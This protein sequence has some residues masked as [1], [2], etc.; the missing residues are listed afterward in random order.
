MKVITGIILVSLIIVSASRT[1]DVFKH[2]KIHGITIDNINDIDETAESLKKLYKP[3][4]ARIVFDGDKPASYYIEAVTKLN[5]AGFV[6]GELL[7]SY[8]FSNYTIGE[9]DLRV[10]EYLAAFDKKI[11]IWEIAN[12][13][14]GEWLGD[15]DTVVKKMIN[16]FRIVNSK[17]KI[18]AVTFYYNSYC[19]QNEKNEMFKWI[20]ENVPQFMKD[21]LN[22][23]FVSYYEDDCSGFQPDWQNIFDSLHLIFPNSK[24]GIGEC[25]TNFPEKKETYLRRY[26][27]MEINT[28]NYIGGYFWWYYKQDCVPYTKQ[29]WKV[30][31]SI[32]EKE[33]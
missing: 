19:Y 28:P 29:L 2:E 11:D 24:L 16:A 32:L 27:T 22:Y 31:N 20:N 5:D 21:S 33:K 30:L 10:N 3:P 4:T 14:N 15:K 6:M 9:Y 25:G 8:N 7:D 13:I 1:N 12:E 17:G 26:Y 23:V 18:T